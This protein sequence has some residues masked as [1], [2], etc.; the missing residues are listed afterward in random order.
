M[1]RQTPVTGGHPTVWLNKGPATSIKLTPEAKAVALRECRRT[2]LSLSDLV[3]TL[4][5][6]FARRISV[7]T[8]AR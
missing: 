5:R 2:G 3:E 1:H 8:D 7:V 4:I 6:R